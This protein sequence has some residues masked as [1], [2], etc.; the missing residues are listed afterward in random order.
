M[1]ALDATK[2]ESGR[3]QECPHEADEMRDPPTQVRR[4][5]DL[6]KEDVIIMVRRDTQTTDDRLN[7][8][9]T[10]TLPTPDSAERTHKYTRNAMRANA[11]PRHT[12]IESGVRGTLPCNASRDLPHFWS[13]RGIPHRV[14]NST[15]PV[16]RH[17]DSHQ[18]GRTGTRTI[19]HTPQASKQT[20]NREGK[21]ALHEGQS[22]C[23]N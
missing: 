7:E 19:A 10:A 22:R 12:L 17:N 20:R 13:P 2:N 21:R 5:P 18:I 11:P 1:P 23:G 4:T 9:T 14:D 15:R 3:K 16:L 8:T 6:M